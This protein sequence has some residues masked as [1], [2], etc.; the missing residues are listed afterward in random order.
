MYFA[1]TH[2]DGGTFYITSW[3]NSVDVSDVS[4][5]W[6][7]TGVAAIPITIKPSSGVLFAHT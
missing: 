4:L 6:A 2:S 7:G 3:G 1:G 5:N